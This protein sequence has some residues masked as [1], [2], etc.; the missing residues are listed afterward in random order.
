MQNKATLLLSLP[1]LNTFHKQLNTETTEK[2]LKNVKSAT[3]ILTLVAQNIK[4][5]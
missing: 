4:R 2:F 1:L 3:V 5:L